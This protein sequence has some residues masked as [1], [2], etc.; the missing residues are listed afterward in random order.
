LKWLE[1]VEDGAERTHQLSSLFYPV[2]VD[3]FAGSDETGNGS[4]SKPYLTPSGALLAKGVDSSIFVK[5]TGEEAAKDADADGYAPISKS[6]G[7]NAKKTYESAIKKRQKQSEAAV[8]A[9][10]IEG[11]EAQ[12]LEESKKII[13]D[14]PKGHYKKVSCQCALRGPS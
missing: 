13:L 1:V 5:K 4:K 3:E 2:Y 14:E 7:K 9:Q 8:K 12:K 10:A 11:N 6:A